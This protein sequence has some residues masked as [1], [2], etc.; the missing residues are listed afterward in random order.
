MNSAAWLIAA[1]IASF[2][3]AIF[4]AAAETS[5]L[6]LSPVRAK[7]LAEEKGAKGRRLERL[8]QRLPHVLNTILLMAL[9]SQIVAATVV[10]ILSE[11]WFGSLGVTIASI[12][13]TIAL[14]IYAEAIPKTY[15]VRH[16]D[17]VALRVASAVTILERILRPLVAALVWIADLQ[18]PG[19][20]VTTSPTVTEGELRRLTGRAAAEGQIDPSDRE[21]IERAFRFGDRLTDDIMVPRTEIVGVRSDATVAEAVKIALEAGHRRIVVFEDNL[22]KVTGLV[23]LRDLVQIPPERS[24]MPVGPLSQP[25]L[26]VPEKKPI[27]ALL[28]EMQESGT[29]LALVVDEYG[30]TAG[31]ATVEDIAEELVGSISEDSQEELV[32]LGGDVWSV[33]GLVP[34]EDVEE[35]LGVAFSEGDW[36]TIGGLMIGMLGRL[37]EVGDEVEDS[38]HVLRVTA[39]RG[40]R[41]LRVEARP[42]EG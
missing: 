29:H 38:D 39:V 5:L 34:V 9:L 7:T 31:L 36:N 28:R 1:L 25:L 37:P 18:A 19:K 30:G 4:L 20:G 24:D 21:L 40:N 8:T 13:L 3:I 16:A 42:V 12:L 11:Q 6:R 32:H 23:R 15:A 33:D 14:F 27:V 10:G 2:G 41:V 17:Q 26:V 22:D 35:A